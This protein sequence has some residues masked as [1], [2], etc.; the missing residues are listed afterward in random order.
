MLQ[1]KK[2]SVASLA[3]ILAVTAFP[4][5]L[6][7]LRLIEPVFAQTPPTTP[8]PALPA[9]VKNRATL[10]IDGSTTMELVNNALKQSFEQQNPDIQVNVNFSGTPAALTALEAGKIDLAAI[11]RPLT[12]A[13]RARGLVQVPVSRNKIAIVVGANNPFA[14]SLTDQQFARI[15][16]GEIRDWSEVGG[17]PGRIR[18]VDRPETSDT[19]EAFRSY[20]VFQRGTFGT[21]P[22]ASRLP[23]DSTQAM[24]DRLGTDGIGYAI[25]TQVINNPGVRIIPMHQTLPDNPRYPFSQPLSYVYRKGNT[26]RAVQSFVGYAKAPSGQNAIAASLASAP[27]LTA[28][29][30]GATVSPDPTLSPD[31]T[32]S[33]GAT[34]SPQTT[35][36]PEATITPA[37]AFPE[38]TITPTP[39]FPEATISPSPTVS[40]GLT[41]T[42]SPA[43]PGATIS[44]T[45]EISPGATITPAPL[46][47]PEATLSP[48]PDATIPQ[49][50][51]LTAPPEAASS[52]AI[53]S[54]TVSTVSN[55]DVPFLWL[56]I[57]GISGLLAFGWW[58]NRQQKANSSLDYFPPSDEKPPLT[59]ASLASE[60]LKN[61]TAGD[62]AQVNNVTPAVAP[63]TETPPTEINSSPEIAPVTEVSNLPSDPAEVAGTTAASDYSS[64]AAANPASGDV[65]RLG[66]TSAAAAI[67]AAGLGAAA[68]SL[69][70]GDSSDESTGESDRVPTPP[71]EEESLITP[72]TTVETQVETGETSE[73]FIPAESAAADEE[74]STPTVEKDLSLPGAIAAGTGA[75]FGSFI[76]SQDTAETPSETP[77]AEPSFG[78]F[79]PET[80]AD[81]APESIVSEPTLEDPRAGSKGAIDSFTTGEEAA[82]TA[83]MLS[84][85]EQPKTAATETSFSSFIP[86]TS[87]EVT[88]PAETISTGSG[89]AFGSFI[90]ETPAAEATAATG[91]AFDSFVSETPSEVTPTV[92]TTSA[93]VAP[94]SETSSS[95][96]E[97]TF[98]SFVS[99]TPSEVT[100]TVETTS[101][102]AAPT[103][104]SFVSETSSEVT[105]TVETSSAEVAPTA[106][107]SSSETEAT[108]GSF[109]SETPSEVTPTVE[110]TSAETPT[111]ETTDL[112]LGAVVAAGAGAALGAF[113]AKENEATPSEMPATETT[114]GATFDSFVTQ[115]SATTPP[116]ET[117]ETEI[118]S[119]SLMAKT[120]M[121]LTT[122][123]AAS[124]AMPENPTFTQPTPTFGEAIAAQMPPESAENIVAAEGSIETTPTE[125][126][127]SQIPQTLV[128]ENGKTSTVEP[129]VGTIALLAPEAE[130]AYIYWNIPA[131]QREALRSDGESKLTLRLYDRA[132]PAP[133][134]QINCHETA[135]DAYVQIPARD[136]DYIAEIG[137]LTND[138]LWLMLARSAAVRIPPASEEERRATELL[139]EEIHKSAIAPS[140]ARSI[141][142]SSSAGINYYHTA[143]VAKLSL[144]TNADVTIYGETA[145]DATVKIGNQTVE[146][147]PD[148]KYSWQRSLGEGVSNFTI[149]ATSA[150]GTE[151]ITVE[152][153]VTRDT[154]A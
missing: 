135:K 3:L 124:E 66:A 106:E 104:G 31:A 101:A 139:L 23:D 84:G 116:V 110:T 75:A 13:E 119:G 130:W 115:D 117:T 14:N 5:P 62:R 61:A 79:V 73:T 27:T 120:G 51:D 111:A 113:I 125:S 92:E 34:I 98:G 24:I 63:S 87:T 133:L 59:P 123:I 36:S 26:S 90:E 30:P 72:E 52:Q 102:E 19:R 70:G 122:D 109:V 9:D 78:S 58:K 83:E 20:P 144:T 126:T 28:Q 22:N 82:T 50:P 146:V 48:T 89:S 136:R 134:E 96:T 114:E 8:S 105:P 76:A 143:G 99:E 4:R 38:A 37:P 47:S 25:A 43:L 145:P 49:T 153:K 118:N 69:M 129:N 64:K 60:R 2:S 154:Q 6:A 128:G 11:A 17:P 137:Y 39:A 80:S 151:T 67:A 12:E 35:L 100:P 15:F 65:T 93:E 141:S 127:P 71:S 10:Q 77:T 91:A 29:T 97:A 42:P 112:S 85:S 149:T 56:W 18:L 7:A 68:G 57:L 40:P 41:I 121:E 142:V 103:F 132:N 32:V 95:E 53:D 33:P 81:S 138:G 88:P 108:F 107:T 74:I 150:D 54:G 148:G 140:P 21:G 147:A 46:L 55:L 44:P 152:M 1:Q 86:E 16:R 94:T 131:E 45:P